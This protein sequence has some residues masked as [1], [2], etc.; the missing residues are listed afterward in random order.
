MNGLC[1]S[2]EPAEQECVVMK[3][4]GTSVQD[5]SSI[6]GVCQLVKKALPRRPVVVVSALAR[7]TDQLLNVGLASAEGRLDLVAEILHLLRQRHEAVARDLVAGDEYGCLYEELA[8]E[9]KAL[10]AA[11]NGIATEKALR[12]V[13]QDRLLGA[14]ESLSSRLVEASLRSVGV[15]AALVDAKDLR[16]HRRRSHARHSAVG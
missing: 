7:V 4:G 3:F 12:P 9:F 1:E 15:D 13:S 6:R 11:A 16:H 2:S 5:A 14:G 10:E 8:A